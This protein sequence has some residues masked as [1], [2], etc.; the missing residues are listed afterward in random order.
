M[1]M[2]PLAEAQSDLPKFFHMA[3]DE[4]ILITEQGK[5][6]GMLVGLDSEDDW[7]DFLLES[8]PRFLRRIAAA[9]D[10]YRRGDFVR[11]ED[12]DE[13]LATGE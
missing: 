6:I 11:I 1:K 13:E 2:I 5:P 7:S 12:L 4:E 3:E 9:R 8:D 10:S